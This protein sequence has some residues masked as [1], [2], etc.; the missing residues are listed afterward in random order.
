[1]FKQKRPRR[2]GLDAGMYQQV[3]A[4]VSLGHRIERQRRHPTHELLVRLKFHI[5]E[6]L[7][8]SPTAVDIPCLGIERILANDGIE[9][10]LLVITLEH[11]SV[12][13]RAHELNNANRI[14][15]AI[16]HVA[17]HVQRIVGRQRNLGQGLVK[18]THVP[19][20]IRCHIDRH[21]TPLFTCGRSPE[22]QLKLQV[23]LKRYP[24]YSV[25]IKLGRVAYRQRSPAHACQPAPLTPRRLAQ[26]PDQR[27]SHRSLVSKM[28]T[29]AIQPHKPTIFGYK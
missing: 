29:P 24:L 12:G 27:R 15:P 5:V 21:G 10:D 23:E 1:M 16:D 17:Q 22:P 6:L 19:V 25:A 20:S 9:H 2:L 7:T 11:A 18:R 26:R 28:R 3:R 4:L 8:G 13:Q 14:G